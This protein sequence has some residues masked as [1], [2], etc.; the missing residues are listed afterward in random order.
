[1]KNAEAKKNKHLSL[2]SLTALHR[3]HRSIEENKK[4]KLGANEKERGQ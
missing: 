4:I 1:M 2:L 3:R